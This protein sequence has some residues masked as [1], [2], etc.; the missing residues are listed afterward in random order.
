MD[1]AINNTQKTL[2]IKTKYTLSVI[3][4]S[5]K[6]K[7]LNQVIKSAKGFNPLE[8]IVVDTS[9]IMPKLEG[10]SLYH[11]TKRLNAAEARNKGAEM[12]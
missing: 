8:I 5:Y 4:P 2:D 12:A 10:V 7:Y 9:P 3:I 11:Q 1:T 6:S